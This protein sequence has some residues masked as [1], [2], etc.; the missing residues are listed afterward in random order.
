[1]FE[2]PK[3]LTATIH[4]RFDYREPEGKPVDQSQVEMMDRILDQ[5]AGLDPGLQE[6]LVTFAS[7]LRGLSKED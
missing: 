5:A 2:S 4:V 1:M 7:H 6:L 3:S